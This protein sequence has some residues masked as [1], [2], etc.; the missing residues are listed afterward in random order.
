MQG[1]PVRKQGESLIENVLS[2]P[3]L[4]DYVMIRKLLM[5][6]FGSFARIVTR[7][8]L[9]LSFNA[10]D[11][12]NLEFYDR[13][14]VIKHEDGLQIQY[15]EISSEELLFIHNQSL[16]N[17]EVF[18]SENYR[19]DIFIM[20]N[21]LGLYGSSSPLPIYYSEDLIRDQVDDNDSTTDFLGF[22][23]EPIYEQY[24]LSVKK[25]KLFTRLVQDNDEP[26]LERVMAFAGL[27][28]KDIRDANLNVYDILPYIGVFSMI[29]RSREGLM[30]ILKGEFHN[31]V[32][33]EEFVSETFDIPKEQLM[34]LGMKNSELGENAYLGTTIRSTDNMIIIHISCDSWDEYRMLLPN[35]QSYNKLSGILGLYMMD[36]IDIKLDV[37][38]SNIQ[39]NY[40]RLG[41]ES[42]LGINSYVYGKISDDVIHFKYM[43]DY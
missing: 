37:E 40:V 23:N 22:L 38:L 27:A 26:L 6:Y 9:N 29:P 11:V 31:R 43:L 30:T 18:T 2:F 20:V 14:Q 3:H 1:T 24:N 35:Q 5:N 17:N 13:R 28:I 10:S 16:Q 41:D 36:R 33:V 7:P 25:Y 42:L 39:E 12:Q 15:R 4:Y 21:F 32:W 8:A 19:V 34:C